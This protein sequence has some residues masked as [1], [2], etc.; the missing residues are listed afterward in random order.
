[1]PPTPGDYCG[2]GAPLPHHGPQRASGG[3]GLLGTAPCETRGWGSV[4]GRGAPQVQQVWGRERAAPP[5]PQFAGLK[6]EA[7]PWSRLQPHTLTCVLLQHL[8]L[9]QEL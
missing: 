5:G 6:E 1:M 7:T 8:F 4:E 9:A 2:H 3:S